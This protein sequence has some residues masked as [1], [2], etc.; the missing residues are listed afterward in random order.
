M[1]CDNKPS[2]RIVSES[3]G[4]INQ[5]TVVIENSLWEGSVG[6]TI[7]SI[8]AAPVDGLP[9]DEP[10]FT[11]SQIP[12]TV[13]NGFAT[14]SRSILKIEKG[15]LE[16]KFLS[17]VM[18]KPQ[19]LILVTG[20]NNK[21]LISQL[22][23]NAKSMVASFKIQE[24]KEKQ[25]RIKLSLYD[26]KRIKEDLGISINFPSVYRVA[27]EQKDFFWIRK[28]ITTGTT[29]LLVYELPKDAIKENDTLISQI[30]KIR[31]SIGKAHI[32]GPTE[33]SYMITEKA[34]TPFLFQTEIADRKTYETKGT[35]EVE[36]AF[37]AGPFINYIIEDEP[38]N[39][40]LVLEGFAFAP[41]VGKRE[42]MFE[43]EAI[44]KSI[45]FK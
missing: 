16:T 25:R 11:L 18:A 4:N 33:G 20:N 17:D 23:E 2:Q 10:L 39:R 34:Y 44:I 37:M 32:P 22:K 21:E 42:Y 6:D 28:D 15:Q 8:L 1:S 45:K 43:L 38:N 40:Y 26:T 31:D 13:F 24:L 30:V 5:L 41:S 7:R 35:W 27:K 19:R 9:Q 36:N 29:N 12:P 3:S 14:K